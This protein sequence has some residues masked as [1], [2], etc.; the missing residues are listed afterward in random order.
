MTLHLK[1]YEFISQPW[2][3]FSG[4]SKWF[5]LSL[6]TQTQKV[7]HTKWRPFLISRISCWGSTAT[8]SFCLFLCLESN[9]LCLVSRLS[10]C[11]FV[12]LGLSFCPCHLAE[13]SKGRML[14]RFTFHLCCH[15]QR[16]DN[17]DY[18]WYLNFSFD[19][20]A[21]AESFFQLL[22]GLNIESALHVF[23]SLF[24]HLLC[25]VGVMYVWHFPWAHSEFGI[26]RWG[27]L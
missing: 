16:S 4:Y 15:P 23:M 26:P 14:D 7:R 17:M 1:L 9:S 22:C 5:K 25:Y 18:L 6:L 13:Q 11:L 10:G 27:I 3:Q 19:L 12:T 21:K 24:G 20:K 8:V 2:A